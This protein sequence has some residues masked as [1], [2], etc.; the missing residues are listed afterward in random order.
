MVSVQLNSIMQNLPRGSWECI[1]DLEV[2]LTGV[3][4]DSRE[5]NSGNLFIAVEGENFSADAFVASAVEK[6]AKAIV[7]DTQKQV[8]VQAVLSTETSLVLVDN[9][10]AHVSY[11]AA[12]FYQKPS[13]NLKVVAV[14]GTD[15]KTSVS[16]F[17]A[18]AYASLSPVVMGTMGNGVLSQLSV[19]THTTPDAVKIQSMIESYVENGSQ[20]LSMEASSHGLDQYRMDA[21]DVDIAVL[22][23]FSRDHL[24]YH[25]TIDAYKSAKKR[26]FTDFEVKHVVVNYQDSF[27]AALF[28]ELND[29]KNILA[30]ALNSDVV[31]PNLVRGTIKAVHAKGF[32]LEL[33][34]QNHRQDI[35]LGLLGEF[36]V[37]NA[38]A[39]MAVLL[40]DGRSFEEA[41]SI[42]QTL[43]PIKGRMQLLDKK[44][45]ASVV[46]DYAHTPQALSAAIKAIKTHVDGNVL[47]VFG[48]GGDRDK[49]KRSMMAQAATEAAYVYVTNDNPRTEN[50]VN[51]VKQI[52]EG[53]VDA[54]YSDFKIE[55]DRATAIAHAL[56]DARS[57]DVVLI[58]GKGHEDYQII[59]EQ[60]IPYS[61]ESV[62]NEYYRSAA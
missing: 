60:K 59:G 45:Y 5:I 23:N 41:A 48:C 1:G 2:M 55:Y 33:S 26:L 42:L 34:Y 11:I 17:V 32:K 54:S 40:V 62:V 61:D 50:E 15:G 52:C 39:V 8:E 36:N 53:F 30:Y 51:I 10:I 24:D 21:V 57:D 43:K 27:G 16:H 4:L 56:N 49:G 18:Q 9:L 44:G 31:L 19:A 3:A 14:T 38:L 28:N 6:G 20:V 37:E 12:A 58:A 35:Q 13:E 25:K 7:C 47:C 22:T 46:I 29:T